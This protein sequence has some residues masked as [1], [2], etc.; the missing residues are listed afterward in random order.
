MFFG[1]LSV[2]PTVCRAD[3]IQIVIAELFISTSASRP[4]VQHIFSRFKPCV[5]RSRGQIISL[6]MRCGW[7]EAFTSDYLEETS[8]IFTA[9]IIRRLHAA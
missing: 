3:Q 5:A 4:A 8:Q 6:P 7:L 1:L 2:V 9:L